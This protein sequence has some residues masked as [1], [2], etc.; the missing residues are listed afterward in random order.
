MPGLG[1]TMLIR[2]FG[3]VMDLTFSRIQFTPDLMPAD[4]VGTE[5]LIDQA[6]KMI[7]NAPKPDQN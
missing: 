5:I 6:L 1:K 3:E 4:I 7:A 2:T